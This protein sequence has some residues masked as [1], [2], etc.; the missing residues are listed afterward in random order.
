MEGVCLKAASKSRFPLY[1]IV[2]FTVA[3][4]PLPAE[5]HLNSTGMGPLYDG[6]MHFV[7]SPEDWVTAFGLALLA[8]LRGA[9]YARRALFMLPATWLVGGFAGLVAGTANAT[10]AVPT[11][12]TIMLLGGLVAMDA[13]LS[14][15]VVAA[16]AALIGLYHGYLNGTGMGQ[17]GAASLALLGLVFAVFVL[18]ALTTALVAPFQAAW[19]RIAVRVVGSWIAASGV[20]MLGW[21]LRGKL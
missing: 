11:V 8:G 6:L 21:D 2:A 19:A 9:T 7:M 13:K 16:L 15:R 12:A 5:A 3:T 4:S 17:P 1:A 20:L 14:L 18:V 10:S